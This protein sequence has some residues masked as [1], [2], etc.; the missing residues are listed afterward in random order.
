ME[1]PFLQWFLILLGA[2]VSVRRSSDTCLPSLPDWCQSGVHL[3]SEKHRLPLRL[4][5]HFSLKDC[6]F[7][8]CHY[9]EWVLKQTWLPSF[10]ASWGNLPQQNN[11]LVNV[12]PS[13]KRFSNFSVMFQSHLRLSLITSTIC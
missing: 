4:D 9:G 5:M 1:L 6:L 3:D 13:M 2:R 7:I 12:Y 11:L 8:G 10:L